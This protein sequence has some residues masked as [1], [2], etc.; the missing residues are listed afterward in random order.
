MSNQSAF[1][2]KQLV[3][4]ALFALAMAY[5]E[6]T[7]VVYL[8]ELFYPA[9]FSFPLKEIPQKIYLIELGREVATM[10]MLVTVGWLSARNFLTR[11]AGFM[12]AFG[13]WDIFYYIFLKLTINWPVDLLEWDVLFLIPL[14]WLGPV[15]APILVSCCL[16]GAGVMIWWLEANGIKLEISKWEWSVFILSGLIIIISF[17]TNTKVLLEKVIPHH[18]FWEIFFVG[19]LLGLILFLVRIIKKIKQLQTGD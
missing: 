1:P 5:L 11:F 7:V 17:L 10:I 13:I 4:L 12:L 9:G 16:M 3:N 2:T 8:R 19:L 6:A 15:L 14:P 18:F